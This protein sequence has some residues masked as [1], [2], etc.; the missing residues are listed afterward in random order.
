MNRRIYIEARDLCRREND[1]ICLT[2]HRPS[3]L[4]NVLE[5]FGLRMLAKTAKAQNFW[6]F[7]MT[8]ILDPVE[9]KG[10]PYDDLWS[11]DAHED[12]P[13]WKYIFSSDELPTFCRL[14]FGRAQWDNVFRPTSLYILINPNIWTEQAREMD[15]MSRVKKLVDPLHLLHSFRGAQVD[16][17]LS[18]SYKG[19][20]IESVCKDCPNALEILDAANSILGD[21]DDQVSKSQYMSGIMKYKLGLTYAHSCRWLYDEYDHIMDGGP[22]S[23]LSAKQAMSNLEVRLTARIARAY[24]LAKLMR[25]ARMYTDR[26]VSSHPSW[27]GWRGN[28]RYSISVQPWEGDVYAEVLHVAAELGYTD[29]HLCVAVELLE[30][31]GKLA[32]LSEEQKS[33][34]RSYKDRALCLSK[35]S[36]KR[37]RARKAQTEREDEK[38]KGID[39]QRETPGTFE[40]RTNNHS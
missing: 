26:A 39:T 17:P 32:S 11:G 9:M 25:M 24:F 15:E 6:N 1:F 19:K 12:G 34:L 23:E 20:I 22:F 35:R 5:D 14:L 29:G 10:W 2:S 37:A 7:S 18:G 21:G 28:G 31:A 16:G 30:D 33:K 27:R 8:I 13:P 3:R 4:G 40:F 36:E 38:T